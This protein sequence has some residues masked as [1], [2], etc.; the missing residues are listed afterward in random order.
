MYL[1]YYFV[2]FCRGFVSFNSGI[3]VCLSQI[4][5]SLVKR[6]ENHLKENG[7][8]PNTVSYY[9]RNLRVIYN[10]AIETKRLLDTG[11]NPFADVFTGVEETKRRALSAVEVN[12][13]KNINFKS[14]LLLYRPGSHKYLC[15][16]NLYFSWRSFFFCL[17]TQG[18][19]FVDLV[20]LKKIQMKDG[21]ILRYCRKKTGKQISVPVN[22]GMQG[23]ID[24][25]SDDTRD[26]AY[27]FPIINGLEG[28]GQLYETAMRTQNHKL[29][30]K[31]L[32]YR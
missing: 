32:L 27:L 3:D 1:A 9:M 25:F 22:E 14:L 30:C 11:E 26:S 21:G 31:S 19:C 2:L 7:K 16:R 15:I 6:F 4:N 20:Y 13:L 24:G 5:A 8:Q 12:R 29:V 17:Y 28:N 18:M 23:I 10:R